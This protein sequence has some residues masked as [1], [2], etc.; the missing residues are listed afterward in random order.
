MVQETD[1]KQF[2][3]LYKELPKELKDAISSMETAN[4]I[5]EIC[6]RYNIT[7]KRV[8]DIANL[9]GKV[10]LGLLMPDQLVDIFLFYHSE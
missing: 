10:L 5:E 6:E 7:D 3:K 8:T 1:Q 2:W 9:V 4:S